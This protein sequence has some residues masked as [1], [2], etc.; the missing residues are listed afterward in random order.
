MRYLSCCLILMMLSACGST[1]NQPGVT[2]GVVKDAQE[3]YHGERFS[4]RSPGDGWEYNLSETMGL[5][6]FHRTFY[7]KGVA[8][9]NISITIFPFNMHAEAEPFERRLEKIQK[10]VATELANMRKNGGSRAGGDTGVMV[11]QRAGMRCILRET[12]IPATAT[13]GKSFR[14]TFICEQPNQPKDFPPIEIGY[15]EST[16]PELPFITPES[17]LNAIWDS[18]QFKPVDRV[19]SKAY[20]DWLSQKAKLQELRKR[21]GR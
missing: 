16:Q 13:A 6:G 1:Y 12:Y 7:A 4:V 21:Y 15:F 18:L 11:V 8:L 20:H 10:L 2:R 14:Q 9:N 3:V 17:T 5:V 19:T